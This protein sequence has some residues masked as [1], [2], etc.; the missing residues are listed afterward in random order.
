M[1]IKRKD[2]NDL[3]EWVKYL[4]SQERR[5]KS[6]E[7]EFKHDGEKFALTV[8][9]NADTSLR[10]EGGNYNDQYIQ[11]RGN[12]IV[13]GT[14]TKR[15]N[16]YKEIDPLA[17]NPWITL[18]VSKLG[19]RYLRPPAVTNEEMA[20]MKNARDYLASLIKIN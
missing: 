3:G 4:T 10:P 16:E 7:C 11:A 12:N 18:S 6:P 2:F 14:W 17:V 20:T 15:D 5:G 8:I 1:P 19:H 13:G 9:L